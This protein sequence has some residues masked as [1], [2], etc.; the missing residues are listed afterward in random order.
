MTAEPTPAK[1]RTEQDESTPVAVG[2]GR[3]EETS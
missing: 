2:S 1:P 3:D